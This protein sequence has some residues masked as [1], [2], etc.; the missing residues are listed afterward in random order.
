M[1]ISMLKLAVLAVGFIFVAETSGAAEAAAGDKL[2]TPSLK[3]LASSVT[4]SRGGILTNSSEEAAPNTQVAEK[5]IDAKYESSSNKRPKMTSPIGGR[6]MLLNQF[7][8]TVTDSDYPSKFKLVFFGYTY[9]PDVCPTTIQVISDALDLLGKKS[10]R[11][12]PV[13]ISVDPD[14][15]TPQVLREYL[16]SFR[17]GF[18]GLTGSKA[19]VDRAAKIYKVKYQKVT[20]NDDDADDYTVDHSASVFLMAPNGKF[21]VKFAYG[22]QPEAMAKRLDEIIR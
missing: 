15:D 13:F 3:N 16:A 12:Q 19:L 8:E 17:P 2:I 14:R 18:L 7:G 10:N 9:C 20:T 1:N 4:N 11:V 22:M 5:A 21:I 6:Y